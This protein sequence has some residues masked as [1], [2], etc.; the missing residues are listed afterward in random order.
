MASRMTCDRPWTPYEDEYCRINVDSFTWKDLTENLNK[1]FGTQRSYDSVTSNCIKKLHLRHSF[2]RGDIKKGEKR[3][4]TDVPIGSEYW[5]GRTLWIKYTDKYT[6]EYESGK[7]RSRSKD[8]NWMIKS[9]YVWENAGRTI[10]KGWLLVFL[11]KN[12]RDCSISNLYCVP[13]KINFMM[14]KNH[15]Y[16]ENPNTT[17]T[18]IKWCE[19]FYTLKEY[20]K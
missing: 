6:Y 16:T 9:R 10:P 11:N 14:A 2:N 17:L 13:K 1:K 3:Q 12:P 19:L 15:W 20:S 4:K 8:R 5:N 7:K 18:A